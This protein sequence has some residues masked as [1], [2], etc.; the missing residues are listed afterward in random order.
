MSNFYMTAPAVAPLPRLDAIIDP[1]LARLPRV[2]E[3]LRVA[4]LAA[5]LSLSAAVILHADET[6]PGWLPE[7]LELPA[8]FEVI[9]ERAIGSTLR[10]FSFSTAEDTAELFAD[11]EEDLQLSGYTVQQDEDGIIDEIIEFSGPGINNAKIIIAPVG[12]GGREIIEFDA[13]LQ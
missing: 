10:M 8:D 6:R 5:F 11:R 3:V 2:L 7:A 4:V 13:S 1:I 9:T 12:D